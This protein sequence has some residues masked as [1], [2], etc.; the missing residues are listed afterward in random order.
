MITANVNNNYNRHTLNLYDKYN[1]LNRNSISYSLALKT[2][3]NT[4][5]FNKDYEIVNAFK[6][7]DNM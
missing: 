7:Y 3:N 2:C 1:H 6:L 5:D 4:C